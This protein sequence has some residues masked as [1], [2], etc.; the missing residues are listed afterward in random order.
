MS[1]RHDLALRFAVLKALGGELTTAK[2]VADC[3]IRDTWRPGD[4]N[5]AALP[6]GSVVAAVTLAKGTTKASITDEAAY[7]AWV[8]HV[9]PDQIE[10][11][12]RVKPDFTD[13]AKAA[14][15]KLGHPVDPATGEEI[16]GMKVERGEPYPVVKP[17]SDAADA[18]ARAWRAG[19][20]DEVVG[21]LLRPALAPGESA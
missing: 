10:T 7:E 18:I 15:R 12:E 16:P 2:R 3:E 1:I 14:A 11:V 20:L 6:D 5:S 4:R 19:E 9:H 8:R 21:D 13:R 17:T